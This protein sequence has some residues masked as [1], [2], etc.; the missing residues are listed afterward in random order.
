MS[1]LTISFPNFRYFGHNY[2]EVHYG[3][4]FDPILEYNFDNR[5]VTE[6]NMRKRYLGPDDY[7]LTSI[8]LSAIDRQGTQ[9]NSQVILITSFTQIQ[10]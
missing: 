6:N 9:E 5:D 2:S 8:F 10:E 1:S 7:D 4:M 3:K